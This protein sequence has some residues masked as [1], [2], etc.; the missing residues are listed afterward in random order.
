[1]NWIEQIEY[2]G[3]IGRRANDQISAAFLWAEWVEE[4]E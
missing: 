2:F 3:E 1:M 4:N